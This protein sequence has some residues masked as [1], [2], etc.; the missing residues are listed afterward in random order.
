MNR[1]ISISDITEFMTRRVVDVFDTMLSL[2]AISVPKASAQLFSERVTGSGGFVGEK[3]VGAIYLHLS[4]PLA[5]QVTA[6]MVGLAPHEIPDDIA[7]ND[8]VGEISNMLNGGL[9]SWICDQGIK[10][11]STTPTIFRGTGFTIEPM[12]DVERLRL[13]FDCGDDRFAVEIHIKFN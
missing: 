1:T 2:K 3:V 10:C 13:V 5:N 7:V 9:K 12:K 11:V 6:A 8:A 4:M